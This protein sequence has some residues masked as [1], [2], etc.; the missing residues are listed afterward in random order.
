VVVS[1]SRS[2]TI[3]TRV[4]SGSQHILRL[5]SEDDHNL[6]DA[7]EKELIEKIKSLMKDCQVVVFE[8]YDKGTITPKVITETIKLA[9][10]LSIP[11][12]AD[13]KNRNF[14]HYKN[15]TLFKPNLKELKDGLKID[16]TTNDLQGIIH[17]INDLKKKINCQGILV[18][19]SSRGVFVDYQGEKHHIN[20]HVRDISD[21]SGAGDTVVSIAA[22]GVAS[23]LAPKLIGELTNLGGG[24]VC[25]KL[26]VVPVDKVDL[27]KEAKASLKELSS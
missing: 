9:N 18:T 22:L 3:K 11:T 24:L 4:L 15:V 21:V 8:D 17:A 14:L 16:I 20:A 26:G 12:V 10:E 27:L 6:D 25:E 13:P 5:D 7:E 19:L 2:T 23:K 1:E